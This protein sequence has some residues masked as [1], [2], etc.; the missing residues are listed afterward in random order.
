MSAAVLSVGSN[1]GDRAAALRRVVD[2]FD[3]RLRAVSPVYET[4][5]WGGVAQDD[6]LNLVLLVADDGADAI[7]WLRRAQ[8]CE[9]AAGRVR[10]RR[11]GP[12]IVDVD[13]ISVDALRCRCPELTLPHPRA[14]RRGFVLQPWCDVDPAAELPGRGRV[15]DLLAALPAVE[16]A[17]LRRRDD[18]RIGGAR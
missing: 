1:L 15:V 11:W 6:F 10:D 7:D 14:H 5:P 3:G 18:V 8:A 4:A 16:R 12:R 2:A 17:G 13:V 9:Q